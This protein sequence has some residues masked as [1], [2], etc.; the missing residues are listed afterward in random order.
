MNAAREGISLSFRAWRVLGK[1]V[2]FLDQHQNQPNSEMKRHVIT[3]AVCAILAASAW[4][5]EQ[6]AGQPNIANALKKLHGA[7]GQLERA[8]L[9]DDAK[10]HLNE[11]TVMLT[12]ASSFLE[13]ASKN[14][15]SYRPA[16]IKA[17]EQ[18]KTE[19]EAAATDSTHIEKAAEFVKTAIEETNKAGETGR[20]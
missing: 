9:G 16:A 4:S 2:A 5:K 19:I 15:G 17:I 8:R 11:A 20:R 18:A 1:S 6:F 10:K 14:K 7:R 13:Q 12:A 3:A